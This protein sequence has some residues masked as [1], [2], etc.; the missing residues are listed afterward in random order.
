[1]LRTASRQLPCWKNLIPSKVSAL[2]FEYFDF[3]M[4]NSA[5]FSEIDIVIIF[6]CTSFGFNGTK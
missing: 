4:V 2:Y 6:G 1:M 5:S 3:G